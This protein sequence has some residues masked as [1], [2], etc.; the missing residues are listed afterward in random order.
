MMKLDPTDY[1][2]LSMIGQSKTPVGSWTLNELLQI[3]GQQAS[4][5][6]IGRRLKSFDMCG[7][8]EKT[9]NKGRVLTQRGRECL[10]AEQENMHRQK[11]RMAAVEAATVTSIEQLLEMLTVRRCLETETARQA[12]L[13]ATD[14]EK[15]RLREVLRAHK[16]CVML[17]N[18]PT[19]TALQFHLTVAA[20]CHNKLLRR[21][22]KLLT[23]EEGVLEAQFQ[24]LVTRERGRHYILEH[25][26][27]VAAI[28]SGDANRASAAM[29]EHIQTLINAIR[30]QFEN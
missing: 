7:Y 22:M 20:I 8:T 16:E 24:T 25:E 5:A 15:E 17:G 21:L 28:V 14:E 9:S 18:D 3:N 10:L 4:T 27:I 1:L 29:G 11:L 26:D 30:E 6:T 2:L 23:Y 12:A 13:C 19:E